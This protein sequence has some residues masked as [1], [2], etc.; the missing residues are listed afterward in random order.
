MLWSG[1]SFLEFCVDLRARVADNRH[2]SA[3][4]TSARLRDHS[5]FAL[6]MTLVR[7]V[8]SFFAYVA[9]AEQLVRRTRGAMPWEAGSGRSVWRLG[10]GRL[11]AG[12][13]RPLS[14][15]PDGAT[16]DP[17][18][19]AQHHKLVAPVWKGLGWV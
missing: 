4:G 18:G 15:Q 5:R 13:G 16:D 2:A 9:E 6:Q 7:S 3:G 10:C 19:A 17:R 8:D 11:M 1:M 14:T 12:R